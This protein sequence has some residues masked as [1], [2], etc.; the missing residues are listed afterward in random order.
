MEKLLTQK[1]VS[2]KTHYNLNQ[3][4]KHAFLSLLQ[5]HI[6]RSIIL[7]VTLIFE[8]I[9]ITTSFFIKKTFKVYHDFKKKNYFHTERYNCIVTN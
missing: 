5:I 8:N 9:F 3:F 7:C 2:I 4:R 6:P 1:L